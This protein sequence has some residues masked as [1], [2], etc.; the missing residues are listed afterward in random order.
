MVVRRRIEGRIF[1][2]INTMLINS[3]KPILFHKRSKTRFLV[4]KPVYIQYQPAIIPYDQSDINL[5]IAI[6][7]YPNEV[8]VILD[9]GSYDM[10]KLFKVFLFSCN[11]VIQ[12]DIYQ[13]L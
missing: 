11:P 6:P 3:G 7:V 13:E 1:E 4:N 8:R 9:P 10:L 5:N 2:R 12:S